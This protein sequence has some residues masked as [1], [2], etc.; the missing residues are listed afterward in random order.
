[1]SVIDMMNAMKRECWGRE[2]TWVL[3]VLVTVSAESR[4]APF[5]APHRT[6]ADFLAFLYEYGPYDHDP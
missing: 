3:A 5:R 6:A 1:M 2:H 4:G